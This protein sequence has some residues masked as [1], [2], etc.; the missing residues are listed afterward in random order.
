[1]RENLPASLAVLAEV[2]VVEVSLLEP[3]LVSNA[4]NCIIVYSYTNFSGSGYYCNRL[5]LYVH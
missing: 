4:A 2:E 3:L 5:P 1:M